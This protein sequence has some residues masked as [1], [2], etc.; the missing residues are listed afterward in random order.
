[1]GY[2]LTKA[3]GPYDHN[4]EELC[5]IRRLDLKIRK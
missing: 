4:L 1:M 5:D 2:G 3:D